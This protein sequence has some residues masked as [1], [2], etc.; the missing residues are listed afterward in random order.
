AVWPHRPRRRSHGALSLPRSLLRHP[1]RGPAA[2]RPPV[3]VAGLL[4]EGECPS[5]GLLA[6]TFLRMDS[7]AEHDLAKPGQ[8]R[9][10]LSGLRERLAEQFTHTRSRVP[11][12]ARRLL[13]PVP[14]RRLRPWQHRSAIAGRP[15]LPRIAPRR[16]PRR[17]PPP[18]AVERPRTPCWRRSRPTGS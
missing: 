13:P 4:Q 7:T 9:H 18:V 5:G 3:H 17:P 12:A 8:L 2:Q 11:V 10:P 14:Q 1:A 6:A 15:R 16:L